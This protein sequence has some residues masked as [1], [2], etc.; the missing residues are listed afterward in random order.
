MAH[1]ESHEKPPIIRINADAEDMLR[2]VGLRPSSAE[3]VLECVGST[4]AMDRRNLYIYSDR[5]R[6]ETYST[7]DV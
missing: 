7:L 6:T 3:Q 5:S 1:L 4:L 2:W